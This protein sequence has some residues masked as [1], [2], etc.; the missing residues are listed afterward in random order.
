MYCAP[1][2][3]FHF[4]PGSARLFYRS[5]LLVQ[6][7]VARIYRLITTYLDANLDRIVYACDRRDWLVPISDDHFGFRYITVI[8]PSFC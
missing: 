8:K 3:L 4:K 7:V 6:H 2:R 5:E 1:Y